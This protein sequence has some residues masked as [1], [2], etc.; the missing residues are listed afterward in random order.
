MSD[1]S[2]YVF[3]VAKNADH[4]SAAGKL[5]REYAAGLNFD[6]SFQKFDQE[7]NE[8]NIQYDLPT[9][10]LM[11]VRHSGVF[12]G[13]AGIRKFEDRIGE[14]K[15]MYIQPDH[16]GLG[17]GKILLEN[18]IELAKKRGYK[19]VRLDTLKN[20]ASALHLY[21][22]FGFKDIEPYRFNPRNDV[23]Y[24]EKQIDENL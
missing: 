23:L 6:L 24:L 14:L 15:R 10:G 13:C 21:R 19:Y 3:Q 11:L 9:G 2:Q 7:L 22:E 1:L 4:F 16:R 12:I 20:L 8:I 18:V 17:L 5:F